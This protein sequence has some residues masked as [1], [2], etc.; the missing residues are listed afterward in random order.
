[1]ES[2]LLKKEWLET[3]GLGGYASS[4]IIGCNT[5][6]YHGLLVTRLAN[7]PGK[8]V[9]LSK[10]EDSA[11][12]DEQEFFLTAHQYPNVLFPKDGIVPQTYSND[13]CPCF[14]YDCGAFKLKKEIVMVNGHNTVLIRY[15]AAAENK[16]TVLLRVKPLTAYRDF[17]QLTRENLSLRVRTFPAYHGFVM[18]PYAGMP[19]FFMQ[20]DGN[21]QFFPAPV[22]YQ[23]FEYAK[24]R[25]RGFEYLED[26]FCP[27]VF[28]ISLEPGQSVL[29]SAS[30]EE[31]KDSARFWNKE[32]KKRREAQK[33]SADKPPLQ[34]ALLR[35]ARQFV[36]VRPDRRKSITAG[37]PWFLEWGRDTMVSLPGLLLEDGR[38]ED[39]RAV[40]SGFARGVKRGILPNYLGEVPEQNAY[41]TADAGLW[42]GWAV[43][44][45]IARTGD[46]KIFNRE[47]SAAL[48]NIYR[49]YRAGTD[50]GIKMLDNHLLKA[51][52]P[53][54]QVTWMDASIGDRPVTPRWGC[55]VEIN[56]LWYNFNC[57]IAEVGDLLEKG[58]AAEARSAAEVIKKSFNEMFWLEDRGY[59][60]DIRRTD[61]TDIS[62][63][64]NQIFAVS[65]PYSPLDSNRAASVVKKVK[66]ELVTPYG[67]RTLSPSDSA[68]R[69]FYEGSADERA[70]AYHNGTVWPWLLGHY[71][72][73]RL[74]T[75]DILGDAAAELKSILSAIAGHLEDAGLGTVSEI[76]D[77]DAPHEPRGSISQAWSVAEILRGTILIEKAGG[78]T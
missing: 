43:Q 35:A 38:C 12:L 46:K 19:P 54:E 56:A 8:F 34:R 16:K 24:E 21:F 49:A 41:N 42:F 28:E 73:A 64:P 5:R 17:H 75:A 72:E 77:G 14:D 37:Y 29:V 55:P 25:E 47:I 3:N 65:L 1:M 36:V 51:G 39:Y 18:S 67:L 58:L 33:A 40:L 11:V 6:K 61:Y 66:E 50:H 71:I 10:V 60:A 30:T 27:G 26:L 74:K 20:C 45:Y 63:R 53:Y 4:T 2:T 57:F 69:P 44:Q 23:N 32:L 62:V 13:L 78:T 48:I 70:G 22:W 15:T 52:S 76:F 9:L 68:Y 59:L 7:P 31:Q